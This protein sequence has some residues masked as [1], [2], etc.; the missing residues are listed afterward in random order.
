MCNCFNIWLS[1]WITFLLHIYF[2]TSSEIVDLFTVIF[3]ASSYLYLSMTPRT[4]KKERKSRWL[5]MDV[6]CE[7]KDYSINGNVASRFCGK[8]WKF[9]NLKYFLHLLFT[10]GMFSLHIHSHMLPFSRKQFGNKLPQ[11]KEIVKIQSKTILC[12]FLF[13]IDFVIFLSTDHFIFRIKSIERLYLLSS[14]CHGLAFPRCPC[15]C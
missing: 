8:E 1:N 2:L 12:C 4:E 9:Q 5:G 11:I 13:N 7:R 3:S 15:S 6:I 14:H 10:K